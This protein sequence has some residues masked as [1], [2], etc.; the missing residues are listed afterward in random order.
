M[1]GRLREPGCGLFAWLSGGLRGFKGIK[2][3]NRA[4]GFV[5][6]FWGS[7]SGWEMR[8]GTRAGPQVSGRK[9]YSEALGRKRA[10]QTRHG[11]S[12]AMNE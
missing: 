6:A 1:Y 7:G 5:R 8:N 3:L 10:K 12:N 2:G 4:I 11:R 9:R